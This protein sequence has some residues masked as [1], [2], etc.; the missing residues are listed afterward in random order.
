[1]DIIITPNDLLPG[2]GSI[3]LKLKLSE[4]RFIPDNVDV[5]TLTNGYL[6]ITIPGI[7][8]CSYGYLPENLNDSQPKL[9]DDCTE[10]IDKFY[11]LITKKG[12]A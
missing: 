9:L 3:Q 6:L 10:I 12:E 11:S 7:Y 1:M 2:F 8:R 5:R 4:V